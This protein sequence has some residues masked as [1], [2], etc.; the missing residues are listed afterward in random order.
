MGKA[1]AEQVHSRSGT[2]LVRA[3]AGEGDRIF[4]NERA[5]AL[6]P[7]AGVSESYLRQALH[8]LVGSGWLVRLRKGLYAITPSVPGVTPAH[9][10]EI[11]MHLVEPA[12]IA[13]RSAMHQHGMT[14]QIPREVYVLTTTEA[15]VPR[16]RTAVNQGRRGGVHRVG[17]A[18]YRFVQVK[19]ERFFGTSKVWLN[20]GRI[21]LTDPERTLLDGLMMPKYCGDFAEVLHAFETRVESLDLERIIEYAL[22]LDTAVA[23][24]LG[25]V[26]EHFG[27]E[28][29]K[30]SRLRRRPV[31]GY[32]PLDPSG[33]RKGACN[34]RWMIQENLPGQLGD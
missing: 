19:P 1:K 22:K 5:R 12:A 20:E 18:D 7:A 25:W 3:L 23:M 9:E 2:E 31:K 34:A 27:V 26:L 17:E 29:K 21:T 14:E 13:F 24:R 32:R 8:H 10:F 33:P 28:P 16:T 15:S 4:T 30:L 11:A 6:A